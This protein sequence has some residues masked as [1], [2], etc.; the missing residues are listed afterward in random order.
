MGDPK[1]QRKKFDTPRFRWRKDVLQEELKLL[2]QYGLRNK[3]ELWRHKTTLSKTRGIARSLISESADTRTKMENEL[4]AQLKK[5]GILQE[6]AV[7]DNV[8]DLTIED[9]LERRLQTIVFR[10]GLARTIFQSRQLITHGH[11]SIDNRRVTIPGYIVP[12]EEEAKIAYSS[13]SEIAKQ[14]HPLRLGL[15]VV[16]KQPE[17]RQPQRGRRG[18]RGGGRF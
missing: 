10:K 16:A 9:I 14:E 11:I 2:G 12:K 5:K 1:K 8:L 3:H 7:L 4:L 17:V 18:G 6:T 15:T 13:E